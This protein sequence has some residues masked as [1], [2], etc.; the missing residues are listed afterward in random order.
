M[1]LS[2]TNIREPKIMQMW[3]IIFDSLYVLVAYMRDFWHDI[4]FK[5]R[6]VAKISVPSKLQAWMATSIRKWWSKE[7][8]DENMV[9]LCRAE[10][11]WGKLVFCT[12][13]VSVLN[14][15]RL[16]R[17]PMSLPTSHY[18]V[19]II[20]SFTVY[21]IAMTTMLLFKTCF[22]SFWHLMS[23]NMLKSNFAAHDLPYS[24]CN[25]DFS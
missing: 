13:T 3:E 5:Q 14:N 2:F 6:Y 9:Q 1:L 19:Y 10:K 25:T 18:M 8:N 16:P 23:H 11:N 17:V 4:S 7:R 22:M 24:E 15:R 12:R 20:V 21:G